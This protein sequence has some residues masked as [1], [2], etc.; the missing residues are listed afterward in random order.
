M[1]TG[2]IRIYPEITGY[3]RITSYWDDYFI[4]NTAKRKEDK[5]YK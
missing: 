4:D 5:Y 1:I 3:D 2:Y